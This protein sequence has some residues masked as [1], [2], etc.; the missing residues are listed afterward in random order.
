MDVDPHTAKHRSTYEGRPYYF[1]NPSCKTK[2]D[3]D[4]ARYLSGQPLAAE[5]VPE[6]TVYTCPM[7]PEI[8]QIGPGTCPICGMALEPELVSL[9][10]GPN[11]ELADMTR[12]FWIGLALAVPVFVLEMGQHLFGLHLLPQQVSN[13]LQFA[14]ATP[15]VLWAGQP[16]FARGIASVRTRHLNMFTLIAIGTGVAY[17]YSLVG[18]FLP[19]LFP[20]GL[21]THDGAVAVYF[22]AAAVI[23]VL[24]LLGQVMELKARERTSGAIKALLGLAPKTA[25][26]V[27]AD[28]T[29]EDVALDLIAKGDLLRVRPRREGAG[30]R[31]H[32]RRAR[33][34]G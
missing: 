17:A 2:F 16:F 15:V 1:C 19:G 6:G 30:G 26:R 4:P 11:A 29:D 8:R 32:R 7:D 25:R 24:V 18:T 33:G 21:T 5:P 28:G 34:A 3:A 31:H 9:D 10:D 23:I 13:Y 12:R 20:H 14:L 22:E 27:R